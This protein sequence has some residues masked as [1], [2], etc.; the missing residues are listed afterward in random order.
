M[1]EE[2]KEENKESPAKKIFAEG[3]G[4]YTLVDVTKIFHFEFPLNATLEENFAAIAFM[5]EEILKTIQ[6]KEKEENEKAECKD[7][8]EKPL[9]EEIQ[10]IAK[11]SKK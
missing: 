7:C 11:N 10:D 5:K 3:R 6:L 1:T 9:S 8:Q 2:A 4:R